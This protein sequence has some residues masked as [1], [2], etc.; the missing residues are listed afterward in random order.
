MSKNVIPVPTVKASEVGRDSLLDFTE[1]CHP[2]SAENSTLRLLRKGHPCPR[3][4]ISL[5]VFCDPGKNAK[6]KGL[7]VFQDIVVRT[8]KTV[9]QQMAI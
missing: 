2:R 7:Q 8:Y 3:H 1:A 4:L 9:F 5:K 6:Y